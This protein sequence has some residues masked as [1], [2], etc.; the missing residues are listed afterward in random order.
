MPRLLG[1]RSLIPLSLALILLGA[2]ATTGFVLAGRPATYSGLLG[3]AAYRIEVPRDWNGSL[4]LYSHGYV[5]P[6][7]ANPARDAGDP[8]THDW[9]LDH[10]YALAGSAYSETGWAVQQGV[11]D[12]LALLQRFDS[13]VG[14][15]R[16][17]IAWGDS[18]GGLI[19]AALAE[20]HPRLFAGSLPMCGVLSG[21][22]GFWNRA[23]DAEYALRLLLA[24]HAG[25]QL[26]HVGQPARN[27]Q[28]AE[29]AIV[30]AQASPAGRARLALVA[31]VAGI[32]GWFLP[33]SAQPRPTNLIA[34]EADQVAWEEH[35]YL[36]FAFDRRAE[37][38][39]RAGGNPSG[40]VG[41]SYRQRLAASPGRTEVEGLYKVAGLD[42]GRD[43]AELDGGARI[44]PDPAA[45]RYAARYA[46]LDGPLEVPTLTV[47]TTGDGL[48]EV[49]TERRF[50]EG[51]EA[52]PGT[53]AQL[54]VA[55][56]G[57]CT[58]T[59]AETIAAFQAL[60]RRLDTGRWGDLEPAALNRAA[61]QLGSSAN[62]LGWPAG[63]AGP[64]F[65]SFSPPA[66]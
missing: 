14:R 27:Y 35:P 37:M 23:L 47:H 17:V 39:A 5:G 50:A 49:G 1:R 63:P 62:R 13:R 9:L 64:D 43:L 59:P 24:P 53:L 12:Q 36:Y 29:A 54:Y 58:F 65:V 25:L 18:M 38:E 48:V 46:S 16:R 30:R 51:V 66:F 57:H 52:A 8:V 34:R 60:V 7:L 26:V 44:S 41:V 6:A 3:G 32:P 28:L 42:L 22:A 19:T 33:G 2:L 4:L 21:T 61:G 40:N 10:G 11:S 45:A 15:P 31:D 20:Q 55:R 56:A